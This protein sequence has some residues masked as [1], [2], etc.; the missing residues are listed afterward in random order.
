MKSTFELLWKQTGNPGSPPMPDY[1][2]IQKRVH[3]A[4]DADPSERKKYMRQKIRFAL[5]VI[6]IVGALAGSALAAAHQLGVL[7]VFFQGNTASIQQYVNNQIYSISDENYTLSVT[8][9]VADSNSAYL[10]FTV[11]ARTDAAKTALMADDFE[12]IDTFDVLALTD[13]APEEEGAHLEALDFGY[14]EEEALRT[15]SSRT[16]GM[17]IYE[18]D[19][20]VHV[21]QLR[22]GLMEEGLSVK[23]PLSLARS[24]T[25]KINA[26]GVSSITPGHTEGG[27][28][29]TLESVTL[30]PLSI[31]MEYS[32][33]EK[34]GDAF[35]L[36]F[37][38]MKDG[39]LCSWG[40]VVG[41]SLFGG[42]EQSHQGTVHRS[43]HRRLR[44]V[45]DLAQLDSVVFNGK[46]Y[47]L[48]G[49]A[50]REMEID[51]A[52]SPFQIP[53]TDALGDQGGYGVPIRALCDGLGIAC[54]WDNDTQTATMSYRGVRLVLTPGSQTALVDGR[55]VQLREIP[56][57]R[58]G[59]LAA[60][61]Q[62]LEDTWH[63]VLSV[64][65]AHR[66]SDSAKPAAWLVIP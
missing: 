58:D 59:R 3:A 50:A 12:Q 2:T 60:D 52:L 43:Y 35:P 40:Q 54:I 47:P 51:P 57:I 53:L 46:A 56:T 30:S 36:L 65:Y 8:N 20:T 62:I 31:Q 23:V 4:L 64:A 29:V 19:A 13:R 14:G 24:V 34:D 11:E 22:L 32:F 6:C 15:D 17:S 55:P 39:S 38:Q 61:T 48:D 63:L 16:Y 5:A 42:L 18:L 27:T 41:D 10:L 66:D 37:F 44:T 33:P 9:S 45:L 21:L 26:V 49:G 28:P 1:C 25:L 7:D